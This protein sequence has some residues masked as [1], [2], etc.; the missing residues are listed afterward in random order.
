MGTTVNTVEIL[1][2]LK[3]LC[4]RKKINIENA[5]QQKR[6]YTFKHLPFHNITMT[7][8]INTKLFQIDIT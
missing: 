5:H 3:I 2:A 4:Q 8:L 7:E 6:K 1:V